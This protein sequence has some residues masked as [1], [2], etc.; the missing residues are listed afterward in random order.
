M[1]VIRTVRGDIDPS[2]LGITAPH[3]HLWCDQG[4]CSS[5]GKSSFPGTS[6]K[7]FMRDKQL[8]EKELK[9]FYTAG[10]RAVAEMTTDGWGRDVKVLKELSEAA[11]IHVIAISGTYVEDCLPD[12]FIQLDIDELAKR[13]V[14]EITVGADGSSIRTGLLK[15]SVSRRVIEQAEE[16]G[17]RA[18]ARAQLRT[19]VAITTHTT[20]SSRFEIEGGNIGRYHLDL[21][22]EEGVDL[23]RVIIGHTD[24][25]ADIRQLLEL[26]KR[27]AFV[28]FDTIG[29]T[30]W[31]LDETRIGLLRQLVEAGFEDKVMLSTDRCRVT[32]TRTHGGPG[33][34]HVLNNFIPSLK[35]SGFDE[36]VIHKLLVKNPANIFSFEPK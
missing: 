17:A 18:V 29:K 30:H 16:K 21:F 8:V 22:E 26:L 2:R 27:G 3:E 33:Y 35:Q 34:A 1:K 24:E 10:G 13:Y 15:A 25:N 12:Y 32:E 7:M 36:A 23:G 19:G 5:G 6:E 28:Q 9:E 4:L 11:D 31:Q 20:A 14:H